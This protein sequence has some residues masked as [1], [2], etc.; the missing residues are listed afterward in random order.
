VALHN[1]TTLFNLIEEAFDQFASAVAAEADGLRS[2]RLGGMFAH[3]SCPLTN[4]LI[5]SASNPRSASRIAPDFIADR[6]VSKDGCR[7]LRH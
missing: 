4:V 7:A 3:A 6:T 5:Q 2:L 1:R